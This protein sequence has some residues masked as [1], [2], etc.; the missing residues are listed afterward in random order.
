[1]LFERQLSVLLL[2][3]S[4]SGIIRNLQNLEW[5]KGLKRLNLTNEVGIEIPEVPEECG[6][7]ESEIE[8]TLEGLGMCLFFLDGNHGETA[9][10]LTGGGETLDFNLA[11]DK[12]AEKGVAHGHQDE[13]EH[14]QGEVV[15]GRVVILQHV[16]F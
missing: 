3:V 9:R 10:T 5:V 11:P 15:E 1:M 4:S 6:N 14:G 7:N 2:D 12:G 13:G 16:L 8:G